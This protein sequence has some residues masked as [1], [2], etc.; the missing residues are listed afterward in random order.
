MSSL[1]APVHPSATPA[2]TLRLALEAQLERFER[3]V[4][5]GS[6]SPGTLKMQQGHVPWLLR[7]LGD[8]PLDELTAARLDALVGKALADGL[9]P[10][11]IQKRFSTLRRACALAVRHQLL[12]KLPDFP[13]WEFPPVGPPAHRWAETWEEVQRICDQL[14]PE[15]AAW[16]ALAVY[17]GQHA[18]DV[19]RM[20]WSDTRLAPGEIRIRCTKNRKP[21]GLWV[22]CPRRLLELLRARHAQ[23]QPTADAPIVKPWP[24]RFYQLGRV[25]MRLGLQ[26]ITA[27]GLRHTAA[28]FVA[29]DLGITVAATKWFGWSSF[30]MMEQVYAHALPGGL[31]E[32]AD[33]LSGPRRPP[34]TSTRPSGGN[35]G[36]GRR[37]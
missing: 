4:R 14:P 31:R 28:T 11:T 5:I 7:E 8:C 23:L 15:R 37:R 33:A 30:S 1:P 21:H 27:T 17:T 32:V 24:T 12:M 13:V 29:A 6:R 19:E 16:L 36:R 10:K 2:A 20:V 3:L 34:R 25:C 18:S 9:A 35:D 26:P 22:K